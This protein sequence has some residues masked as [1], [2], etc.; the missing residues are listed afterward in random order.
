MALH[1]VEVVGE[2]LGLRVVGV[3]PEQLVVELPG[4]TRAVRFV[5]IG[6]LEQG[7]G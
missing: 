2:S 6:H 1:A 7:S 5:E 3:E 4:T